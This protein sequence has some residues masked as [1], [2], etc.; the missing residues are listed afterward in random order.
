MDPLAQA[1]ATYEAALTAYA[2]SSSTL[3][4]DQAAAGALQ[5]KLTAAQ[6]QVAT[7]Q[8]AQLTA[9]GTLNQA[10]DALIT[11]ATAAK[12]PPPAAQ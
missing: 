8:A 3:S 10:L 7:D 5:T 1:I 4:N 6:A 9:A 2:N 11:A 12:V